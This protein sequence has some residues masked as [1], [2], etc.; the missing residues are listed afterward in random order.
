MQISKIRR[1]A[2]PA[3]IGVPMV[4]AS[5]VVLAAAQRWI[6]VN[7]SETGVLVA[8][9][10]PDGPAAAAG[11]QRGDIILGL[12]GSET[13]DRPNLLEALSGKDA[14][15][16]VSMAIKRGTQDRTL[17]VTVGERSG[18]PYLGIMFGPDA[19]SSDD[20]PLHDRGRGPRRSRGPRRGDQPGPGPGGAL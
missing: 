17:R 19:P 3:L 8:S 11:L 18:I 1:L 9:V 2:I 6:W 7:A 12:D 15:D 13:P 4:L 20:W 14:E 16:T 5:V 10:D